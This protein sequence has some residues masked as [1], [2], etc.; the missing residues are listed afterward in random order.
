MQRT[1]PTSGEREVRLSDQGKGDLTEE[2]AFPRKGRNVGALVCFLTILTPTAAHAQILPPGFQDSVV[3]SGLTNPTAVQFASDG[4][5]FV[6]EKSGLIKIFEDLTDP[7]PTVFADLRTKVHNFWDRGLLGMALPPGFPA[8]PYVYVLYTYDGQPGGPAP[9]WGTAGATSDGCPDPPGGT[10]DGCVVSGRLSRL[11]IS[12]DVMTGAEEVLVADWFQQ[13]PSHSIGSLAFGSD[14]ALYASGGD[15]ASFNF[16]DYGQKGIPPNPGGDPPVPVGGTQTPPTAEGGALRSQ[17]V[18]TPSDPTGLAGAIIRI[19]PVTGAGLPDN[20]FAGS[21]D[22]NARR[23]IAFGLRNPFRFTLRPGSSEVYIGDVGWRRSEEINRIANAADS[24]AENFGWPCYEGSKEQSGYDSADLNL[25][26]NLYATPGADTE[27]L[28]EYKHIDP[29]VA[30]ETCPTG[31]SSISGLAFY[32]GGSYPAPYNGAL[33]FADYSRTCIWV[34]FTAGGG[35]PDP[36]TRQTFVSGAAYPVQLLTGPGGDLFYVDVAG[37]AI[38]RIRYF[39]ANEP[40]TAVLQATP[41]SGPAPLTVNFDGSASSDSDPGDTLSYAWDLDG[42]GDFD[43][44]TTPTIQNAYP[45]GSY[46]V[47]LEVTDTQGATATA[48]V[49]IT[50][51][52]SPPAASIASPPSG[53]TWEVGE[54]VAFS[55]SATDPQ[56]G[57]L[58]ASALYWSLILHHCTSE[59]DCHQHFVQDFSGVA[60][61]SFSLPEHEDEFPTYLELK[62]TAT[63]SGGLQDTR[64]VRLDYKTVLLTFESSPPGLQL[65]FGSASDT[66]PFTRTVV[67]GATSSISAP[68]P[69]TLSGT[70]YDFASWSD[71]GAQSHNIVAPEAPTTYLATFVVQSTPSAD[72]SVSQ[73]DFPDPVGAGGTL[74]YTITVGNAGPSDATSLSASD[75]I[76]AGVTFVSASGSGWS[77]SGTAPVNCIRPSLPAGS[78]APPITITVT[79]PSGSGTIANT[80]S[81]SSSV[82][83]PNIGNNSSTENTVVSTGTGSA[84]LSITKGDS[85]EPVCA[86]ETVAYTLAVSNSGPQTASAV[87][88]TDTLPT[89]TTLVSAAGVGWNCG[90]SPVVTCTRPSLAVAAAPAITIT[91]T[92][93][94]SGGTITNS[95]SVTAATSDP[96]SGNNSVTET[97][98]VNPAPP[99]PA[100]GN[101]GPICALETLQLTASAIPGAAYEWT[102]PNGFASTQQN[103]TIPAVSVSASGT[104]AVTATVNGCTSAAAAT[105]VT[106]RTLPSAVVSIASS[107]CPLSANNSASVADAGAGASYSWA[108]TNGTITAGAGTPAITFTAGSSGSVTVNVTVTN[109]NGCTAQ[110]SRTRPI[111]ATCALAFHT[112]TPC[113]VIDTRG[114][115]GPVGGPALSGNF[116]RTFPVS[117]RCG[118]PAS[119]RA[120]S[121][122]LTVTQP[123]AMGDLRVRAGG[124]PIPPTSSINYR[125]GQTRANNAVVGLGTSGDVAVRCDQAT[126]SVHFI[127]DVNGYFE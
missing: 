126:G 79:A 4:R 124:T 52:N 40:P 15:G 77:C 18:R 22:A 16:T 55:G 123:T 112:V 113:R 76:P 3:F 98:V 34:M 86:A 54:T 2:S 111:T 13:Y 67:V 29:V 28:F 73:A 30:G 105:T 68:S 23:I 81:V 60:S 119:A 1:D 25:C 127:L 45:A 117:G 38:H 10:D 89:G 85:P 83:D 14:G 109:A 93:P 94:A 78:I 90:G 122:N 114:A 35:G 106:V 99:S 107:L 5:V 37:G 121:A 61:G 66:A 104:Y 87:S 33:F 21:E 56:D 31:G 82:A 115:F 103:P 101:N 17:D 69:Q 44:A 49:V 91:V 50:S 80:A 57:T 110:A 108:I 7:T 62:L 116:D 53:T 95:A 63:D 9:T 96:A 64:S 32:T 100:A 41:T 58:P 19:N 88:V 6:A 43:D 20:P 74:T 51:A 48:S 12:G 72:L 26:E 47:G 97:T 125:P 118:I 120:L 8:D 102:G 92:A 27:P 75:T 24:I 11:R 71:G 65:V 59:T 46:T 39:G 42:D 84:D 70:T 36:A